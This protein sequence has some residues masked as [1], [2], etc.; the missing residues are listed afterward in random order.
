MKKV[1]LLLLAAL[2]FFPAAAQGADG[3]D[4]LG[5]E[6]EHE[7]DGEDDEPY[8]SIE[9]QEAILDAKADKIMD[10]AVTA[11]HYADTGAGADAGEGDEETYI[12]RLEVFARPKTAY[13][14]LGDLV[15]ED[16]FFSWMHDG[17]RPNGYAV[18]MYPTEENNSSIKVPNG[19]KRL[20]AKSFHTVEEA[21]EEI[22]GANTEFRR[23]IVYKPVID[24]LLE[25]LQSPAYQEEEE[26]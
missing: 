3:G 7:Y 1:L 17:H 21:E 8:L 9:D 10:A 6:T 2:L 22:E 25:K 13:I 23:L 26:Q 18:F 12:L 4:D 11:E 16:G 5:A 20:Y 19:T 14:P 15:L 24:A